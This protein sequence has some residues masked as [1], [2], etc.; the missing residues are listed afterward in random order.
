MRALKVIVT[1]LT[2]LLIIGFGLLI[3][4][5]T[6]Q[7]DKLAEPPPEPS[8]PLV[9]TAGVSNER[10]P[11]QTLMLSQPPGTRVARISSAG[12]LIVLHLFTGSE[13]R[14]DRLVVIDPGSG[15]LLGTITLDAKQP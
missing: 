1:V 7:V 9:G 2:L 12:D 6:R 14:D 4:G 3:W 8:A 11:W 5:I 10:V 15:T 13:G